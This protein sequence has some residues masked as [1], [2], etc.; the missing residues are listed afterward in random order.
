MAYVHKV[1]TI[2]LR[3]H[4]TT[5]SHQNCFLIT[6]TGDAASGSN[7]CGPAVIL[8]FSLDSSLST[9]RRTVSAD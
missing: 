8:T 5:L 3:F 9:L 4:A 6:G 2:D 7:A 1:A